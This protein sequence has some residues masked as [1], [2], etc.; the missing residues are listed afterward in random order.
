MISPIMG[1]ILKKEYDE[2]NSIKTENLVETALL[3]GHPSLT[4]IK[5]DQGSGFIVHEFI[6]SLIDK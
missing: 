3:T 5:Y 2:K 1:W 6:K 4:E